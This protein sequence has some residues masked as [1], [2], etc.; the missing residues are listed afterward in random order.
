M[1]TT[2]RFDIIGDYIRKEG[3][4]KRKFCKRCGLEIEEFQKM[5]EGDN[6]FRFESLC[7]IAVYMDIDL[8]N[9]FLPYPI[10]VE[11]E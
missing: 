3:L 2:F 7:K 1:K 8:L 4:T 10:P 9:F 6:S 5:H 11:Y